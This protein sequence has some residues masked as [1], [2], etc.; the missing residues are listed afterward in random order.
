M[1]IK[2]PLFSEKHIKIFFNYLLTYHQ[3]AF[4]ML[5]YEKFEY[6]NRSIE[7]CKKLLIQS[8]LSDIPII[9]IMK[10]D[11]KSKIQLFPGKEM[12]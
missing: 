1:F 5:I 11:T 2:C 9:S 4:R 6:S 10:I 3:N 7:I 8:F 12:T